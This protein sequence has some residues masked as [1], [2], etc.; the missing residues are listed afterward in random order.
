MP[1]TAE[2]EALKVR[3]CQ[4]AY[5]RHIDSIREISWGCG[6]AIGVH[7]SLKRDIDL[8]AVPWIRAASPA[9]VL[10]L[11]IRDSLPGSMLVEKDDVYGT[12][13]PHGRLAYT[14]ILWDEPLVKRANKGWLCPF[15]DLSV[16]P[17][18]TS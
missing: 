14:I 5:L 9:D 17:R 16:L 11:A 6:Y 13:K 12:L 10:A 1:H 7:G 18:Q 2:E 8:I 15:I 3:A 4:E